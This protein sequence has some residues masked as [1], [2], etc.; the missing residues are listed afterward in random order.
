MLSADDCWTNYRLVVTRIRWTLK[1]KTI[2]SRSNP[3]SRRKYDTT[4]IRYLQKIWEKKQI[5][6][7]LKDTVIVTIFKKGDR[8][9]CGNYRGISLLSIAGKIIARFLLRLQAVT[10]S[11]F[12]ESQCGF[13]RSSGT[14]D[15]IFCARQIQEKSQEQ[16]TP[17]FFIFYDLENAFDSVSREVMWDILHRYGCPGGFLSL[18]KGFHDDMWGRVLYH[19]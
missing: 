17:V 2:P 18:I 10:E 16:Q 14:I 11:V 9:L 1:K 8:S 6:Q 4:A 19:F 12:P 5:P 15:M 3:P 7:D 13:R